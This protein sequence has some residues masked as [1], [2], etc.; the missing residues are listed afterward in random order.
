MNP[1]IKIS[2][3]GLKV[4]V[5][6]KEIIKGLNLDLN[7]GEIHAIMGP[8]GSGKTTLSNALAGHP[9]YE[10]E[11]EVLLNGENLLELSPDERAKKGIFL[12]FQAPPF[13]E[14][15]TVLQLIKKSYFKIKE[16][17]ENDINEYKAFREKL[18]EATSF[19]GLGE[20]FLKREV[21]KNFSGG[22]KKKSEML[23]MLMLEPKFIIL[24]EVDSGLDVDALRTV[25][26]AINK[27]RSPERTFLIITHYNRIL[28]HISPDYVHVM[29]KGELIKS[30]GKDLAE[31]IEEKGYNF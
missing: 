7:G 5:E 13:L 26:K 29:M 17:A 3:K 27:L 1:K 11:G 4:K 31:L 24:D 20:E 14:G 2:I 8:N 16:I 18:D 30:G 6:D 10:A 23:Q 21:N 22:E 28:K 15:I 19:L 9:Y 12:S 25:S